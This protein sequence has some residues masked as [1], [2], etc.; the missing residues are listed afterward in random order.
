LPRLDVFDLASWT[1]LYDIGPLRRTLAP[2]VELEALADRQAAP[3]LI[4]SAMD[5][6]AGQITYFRSDYE[7]LSLD[8]IVASGS[9]PPSFAM[10]EIGDNHY[11]DGGLFDNTP[12]GAVLDAL[13][14]GPGVDLTLHVVNFCPNKALLPGNMAEVAERLLNLQFANKTAEDVKLLVRFDE[15]A[16]LMEAL[17]ALPGAWPNPTLGDAKDSASDTAAAITRRLYGTD[18]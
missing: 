7:P 10:T 9:L 14:G 8:H 15:V 2:L 12:L 18:A 17:E 16:Q 6:A 11:W 1:N 13:Q 5:V 4:V 3:P